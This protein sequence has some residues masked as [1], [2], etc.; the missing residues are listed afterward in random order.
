MNTPTKQI[1]TSLSERR[2]KEKAT[3]A[4]LRGE[5]ISFAREDLHKHTD[6]L[7]VGLQELPGH[8]ATLVSP[9]GRAAV[10]KIFAGIHIEWTPIRSNVSSF[11]DDWREFD[12]M[13]PGI[14]ADL[15]RLNRSLPELPEHLLD[16]TPVDQMSPDQLGCM[17]MFAA[18][19]QGVRAMMFSE[20][21]ER[22]TSSIPNS[23]H[24]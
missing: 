11:P 17:M 8:V 6:A 1:K 19:H 14:V 20:N 5:K 10:E 4:K 16:I 18:N 7:F 13:L 3:K 15:K 23:C 22:F 12:F 9:E 21:T 2:R 24:N